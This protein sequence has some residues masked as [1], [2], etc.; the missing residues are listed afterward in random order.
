MRRHSIDIPSCQPSYRGE[1]P[2]VM[3]TPSGLIQ[4]PPVERARWEHAVSSMLAGLVVEYL[5]VIEHTFASLV[6]CSRSPRPD[7]LVP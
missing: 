3:Q 6:S 1:Q 4:V 2:C 7:P 5:D